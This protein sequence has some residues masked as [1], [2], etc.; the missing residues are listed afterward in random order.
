M[1]HLTSIDPVF[2]I[3]SPLISVNQLMILLSL[4]LLMLNNLL[5]AIVLEGGRAP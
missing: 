2:L 5:E 3:N 4:F 1:I